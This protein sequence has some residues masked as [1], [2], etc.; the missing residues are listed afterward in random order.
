MAID[1][2]VDRRRMLEEGECDAAGEL[3]AVVL[4]EHA[5]RCPWCEKGEQSGEVIVVR[6][7]ERRITVFDN[8]AERLQETRCKERRVRRPHVR[9]CPLQERS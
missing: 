1:A 2:L 3:D 7:H 6:R 5:A 9:L 4:D 8:R